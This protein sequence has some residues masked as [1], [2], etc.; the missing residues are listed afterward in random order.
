[1]AKENLEKI[2]QALSSVFSKGAETQTPTEEYLKRGTHFL[3]RNELFRIFESVRSYFIQTESTFSNLEVYYYSRSIR[4]KISAYEFIVRSIGLFAKIF[5]NLFLLGIKLTLFPN[6]LKDYVELLYGLIPKL[7]K[8][9]NEVSSLNLQDRDSL[10]E[11]LRTRLGY[12]LKPEESR[13][14]SYFLEAVKKDTDD[15]ELNNMLREFVYRYDS[16][17]KDILKLYEEAYKGI[18]ALKSSVDI[19]GKEYLDLDLDE[20]EDTKTLKKSEIK[21]SSRRK[22]DTKVDLSDIISKLEKRR[23]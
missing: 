5:K 23:K 20:I 7:Q 12:Y 18:S 21:S 11:F 14:L 16:E 19:K 2:K 4:T 9:A 13:G 8:L 10:E 15:P 17:R 3:T 1:M 22:E 6:L